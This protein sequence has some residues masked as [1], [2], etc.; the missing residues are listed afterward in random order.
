MNYDIFR[1][2]ITTINNTNIAMGKT[3]AERIPVPIFPVISATKPA[4]DGPAV[5]PI[6]PAT[7]NMANIAVPPPRMANAAFDIV[8]GHIIPTEKPHSAHPS[9]PT[10]GIGT[11]AMQR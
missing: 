1:F 8:P 10:T 7:A 9:N 6:S 4:M 11:S 2:F 5:Q 3:I